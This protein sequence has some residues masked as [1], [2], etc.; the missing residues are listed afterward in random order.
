MAITTLSPSSQTSAITLPATGTFGNVASGLPF[1]IYADDTNFLSGAVDQVAFTYRSFGGDVLDIELTANN[2]Y[3]SYETAVLEYSNL[4]NLHQAK[5]VLSDLLGAPTGCFNHDGE[6]VSGSALSASLSNPISGGTSTSVSLRYAQFDMS[7]VRDIGDAISQE[8]NVGGKSTVY[9]A[10]IDVV[11]DKQDYDLQATVVSAS[12]GGGVPYAGLVG[13]NRI[14]VRKVFYKT[15]RA[16][17]RFYGLYGGLN[18]V[19]NLSSYGQY[20]DDS[21][22]EVI[23]AWHNKLQAK[24]YESNLFTRTSHYSYELRNN[25]VRFFPAPSYSLIEKMWFEF[26]ISGVG[27]NIGLDANVMNATGSTSVDQRIGGVNNVNTLPFTNIPFKNINAIG[28]HW[29]RRYALEIAKGML[30]QV[31]SKFAVVPIPGESVTL[32]GPE[33]VSSA[34]E[35]KNKLREELTTYLDSVTYTEL[36]S[37]RADLVD[38]A[39]RILEKIPSAVFVG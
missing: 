9:S 16:M 32:N 21:T 38:A 10:S 36:Q 3:S 4:I 18:T 27:E 24:A 13:N 35:A 31:R 26:T 39:G 30:G 1:G 7:S 17:W 8:A 25:K 20:A 22:F 2:V 6:Y 14:V 12:A 19:G 34:E 28:K 5:N 15:P 11:T 33:L 37:Q 23:P 29:I